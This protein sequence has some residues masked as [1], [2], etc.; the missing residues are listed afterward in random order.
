MDEFNLGNIAG[1]GS[2][3]GDILTGLSQKWNAPLAKM[4]GTTAPNITRAL[5]GV[6][7]F[8]KIAAPIGLVTGAQDMMND[9]KPWYERLV[10]GLSAFGGATGSA[11]TIASL[12]GS[13]AFSAGG[14]S[15]LAAG[16]GSALT[17]GGAGLL[18]GAGA[19]TAL[20]S[21]G[22]VAGAGAAGYGL[23]RIL[24]KGVGSIANIIAGDAKEDRTLSGYGSR[25]LGW[26]DKKISGLWRDPSKPAYTQ[27]IGW[28]LANLLGI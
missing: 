2:L 24:D 22:A 21:L 8:G 25:A 7:L 26:L 15:G 6:S 28:K 12:F 10:G 20:G 19:T 4:M 23:G 17:G 5:P 1:I 16:A 3:G 11:S 9:K 14:A 18:T 27:S 13:G